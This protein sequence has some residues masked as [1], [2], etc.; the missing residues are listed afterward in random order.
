MLVGVQLHAHSGNEI[1]WDRFLCE[2]VD[3]GVSL[4]ARGRGPRG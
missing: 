1:E 4:E 2:L 3:S